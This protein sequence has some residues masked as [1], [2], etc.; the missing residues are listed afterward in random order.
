MSEFI[1]LGSLHVV[2]DGEFTIDNKAV[3]QMETAIFNLD[4]ILQEGQ[5][6][7]DTWNAAFDLVEK[8]M[9]ESIE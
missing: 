6:V 1:E 8:A 3:S 7:E 9:F 4:I 5:S 2:Q